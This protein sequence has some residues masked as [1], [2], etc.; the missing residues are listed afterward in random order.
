MSSTLL[1]DPY[2]TCGTGNA[3]TDVVQSK[4]SVD[5]DRRCKKME[6]LTAAN[7]SS[8]WPGPPSSFEHTI[9][10]RNF[11]LTWRLPNDASAFS[12]TGFILDF[13]P[14]TYDNN[15]PPRT[16]FVVT[17]EIPK[18]LPARSQFIQEALFH[19]NCNVPYHQQIDITIFL[20]PL[21]IPSAEV[22]PNATISLRLADSSQPTSPSLQGSELSHRQITVITPVASPDVNALLL[23][24]ALLTVTV[25]VFATVLFYVIC[26]RNRRLLST[27]NNPVNTE[28]IQPQNQSLL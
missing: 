14:E 13:Q 18:Y 16:C 2:V 5:K 8:M 9:N 19:M 23:I 12:V 15:V 1:S 4:F 26:K 6:K 20:F 10:G 11:S 27:N 3:T 21:P 7:R 25:A 24:S 28:D 17:W 22:T